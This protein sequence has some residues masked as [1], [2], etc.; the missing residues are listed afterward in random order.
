M[1]HTKQQIQEAKITPSKTNTKT[2]Q[3]QKTLQHRQ[4]I[5]KL[6]EIKDKEKNCE[7]SQKAIR[8]KMCFT[9]REISI[10]IT[11]DFSSRTM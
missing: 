1:T 5:F 6:Q 10:R 8:R 7:R 9:Y 11:E 4:I 2:K 3:K